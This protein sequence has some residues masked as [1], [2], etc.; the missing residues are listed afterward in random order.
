MKAT[1][2]DPNSRDEHGNM[3]VRRR[4]PAAIRAAYPQ[5]QTHVIRSLGTADYR[6]AKPL[7]H[8][9]LAKIAAEFE[10]KRQ[11]LD[12]T[13]ASR[14]VKRVRTLSD[15]QLQDIARFWMHEML[16]RDE[17]NRQQG[18][19]D[20][21]F[22]EPSLLDGCANQFQGHLSRRGGVAAAPEKFFVQDASGH[23]PRGELT[24]VSFFI[25]PDALTSLAGV[26][27]GGV[28]G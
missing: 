26:L 27:H 8:A 19:D 28:K 9:E 18:L 7:A 21:E 5:H 4:I 23:T 17:Q 22:D 16:F 1:S 15:R 6:A 24:T 13:W 3:Y 20:D 2:K 25:S 11:Q 12:L 14:A 10:L